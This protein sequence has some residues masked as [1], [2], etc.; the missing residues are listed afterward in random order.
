MM[1]KIMVAIV[2]A[3]MMTVSVNASQ[4]SWANDT[5]IYDWSGAGNLVLETYNSYIIKLYKSVDA[6]IEFGI[7]GGIATN[8]SDD[9]WTGI[10]FNWASAGGDGFAT[11]P[12]INSDTTYGVNAGDLIYSVIFNNSSV[13]NQTGAGY[14]AIIDNSLATASYPGGNMTYDPGGVVGGLQ[15]SGGDWQAVPEPATALLFG[16]GGMGAWMIRRSKLKS[17]EEADA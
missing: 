15:G 12:L 9:I 2:V 1:K 3:V 14:F 5:E 8:Q 13:A 16:I 6:T 4:I 7:A 17:K 11:W 10:A